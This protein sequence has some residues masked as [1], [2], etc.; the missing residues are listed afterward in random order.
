MV[1]TNYLLFCGVLFWGGKMYN[2]VIVSTDKRFTVM[3]EILKKKGF[4]VSFYKTL[5][6]KFTKNDIVIL[7][8]PVTRDRIH[9]NTGPNGEPVC[10]EEILPKLK[11]A[12][13]VIGGVFDNEYVTD[14]IKRDDFAYYNAV[15][16]A[17]GAISLAINN[18]DIT[19]WNAKV[20]VCGYGRVGKILVSRLISFGC[21]LYVSARNNT[22]FSLLDCHG[23]KK[24]NTYRLS[25]HISKFDI[26]F[27]TVEAEVFNNEV[28]KNA[29]KDTLFVELATANAGFDKKA[30]IENNIKFLEAP[31][32]PGKTAFI[33]AGQIISQTVLNILYEN[34]LFKDSQYKILTDLADT[35]EEKI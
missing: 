11:Y 28:L 20:L 19:L 3:A 16:T 2:I 21:D 17:E 33:T 6:T 30:V 8:I 23:I 22:D 9:L 13:L 31:S 18:T 5:S 32:L 27:N 24:I 7:P 4:S 34:Q 15:P 35:N 12:R 29:R 10:L 14:I 25:E 1:N 26:V